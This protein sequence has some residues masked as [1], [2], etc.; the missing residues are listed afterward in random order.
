MFVRTKVFNQPLNDWDVSNVTSMRL[1]FRDAKAFNQALNNWNV[2]N[3][4]NMANMFHNAKAF[5]D[6]DLSS[7]NVGNVPSNKHDLF[8]DGSGY[9]NTEPTW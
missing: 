7:W 6:Q 4:T 3:V 9:G 2:G 5:T 1:M 8:V